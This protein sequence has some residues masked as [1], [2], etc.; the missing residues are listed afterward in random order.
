LAASLARAIE[1]AG[2]TVA[3]SEPGSLVA[4]I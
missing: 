4:A 3:V 2:T 1:E